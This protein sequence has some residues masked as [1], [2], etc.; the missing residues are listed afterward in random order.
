MFTGN[1]VTEAIPARVYSL[2]KI[3]TSKKDISR[4]ELKGLMEPEGIYE[5]NSYFSIILKAA[6][7]LKLIDIQDTLIV[8]LISKDQ[9]KSIDDFR[10]YTISKLDSFEDGQFYKCT[11]AIVNMNEKVYKYS[12]ISDSM[13][14]NISDQITPQMARGWRFWAQFLGFG[15]MNNMAFLPNAYVFVK[16]VIKLMEL[17]K[18]TE[19]KI[20]DFMNRFN[21][22]GK[23]L[24][25]N[26]QPERHM[27]IALS[28]A[29]RELHD[30]GE[31]ELKHSSDA[32]NRWILYP[33][34]ELFNEQIA[35]IIYKGVKR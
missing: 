19:Y 18:K 9:I 25:G 34:N 10:L 12:S 4:T 30:N 11:N 7:E 23:I 13:L 6:T 5:G 1:M 33:S 26:L 14:K 22:Y 27:N 32:E 31:I 35:S 28:G 29:L 24:S 8:P 20:D 16:D 15:Y 17:G 3:A 21:Q 2:Y